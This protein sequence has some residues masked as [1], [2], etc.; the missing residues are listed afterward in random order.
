MHCQVESVIE[1]KHANYTVLSSIT[2]APTVQAELLDRN[3]DTPP[4]EPNTHRQL[5]V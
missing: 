2:Y 4:M 5:I 1:M 3:W